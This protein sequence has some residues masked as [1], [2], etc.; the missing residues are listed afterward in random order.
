MPKNLR[1]T[2]LMY[3]KQSNFVIFCFSAVPRSFVNPVLHEVPS[4]LASFSNSQNLYYCRQVDRNHPNKSCSFSWR[5][6]RSSHSNQINPTVMVD[7]GNWHVFH[8]CQAAWP[9]LTRPIKVYRRA[10]GP[11]ITMTD[12]SGPSSSAGARAA[13]GRGRS[14]IGEPRGAGL[15]REDS[16]GTSVLTLSQTAQ[17]ESVNEWP[18]GLTHAHFSPFNMGPLTSSHVG[19]VVFTR[20]TRLRLVPVGNSGFPLRPDFLSWHVNWRIMVEA[21]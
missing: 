9:V 21:N 12:R 18:A 15:K 8:T 4:L 1:A 16:W 3:C 10:A 11:S 17:R 20:W 5:T 13:E 2:A 14:G 6:W 7:A 19:V